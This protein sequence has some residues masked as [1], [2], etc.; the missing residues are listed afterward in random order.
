MAKSGKMPIRQIQ[1]GLTGTPVLLVFPKCIS[2]IL[3]WRYRSCNLSCT[4]DSINHPV[5]LLVLSQHCWPIV[6]SVNSAPLP[7]PTSRR[8]VHGTLYPALFDSITKSVSIKKPLGF[9][10][11]ICYTVT[12]LNFGSHKRSKKKKREE[13]R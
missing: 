1:F 5:G 7:L 4:R 6:K 10:S 13:R 3:F 11:L 2:L 12:K 8:P 9:I